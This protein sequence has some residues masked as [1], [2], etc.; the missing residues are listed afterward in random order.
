MIY[1]TSDTHLGHAKII[2][3]CH[4]PFSSLEEMD[5]TI[6]SRWNSRVKEE[7]TVFFLGDFCFRNSPG[8]REGI[9]T[10]AKT[11]ES[12]LNGKIVFIEG[13][14]D[15]NN[16]LKAKIRAASIKL[17]GKVIWAVHDPK[18]VNFDYT[19]NLVGHIH[20]K[21]AF[22]RY[23]RG[24]RISDCINVGVDVNNFMPKTPEELFTAHLRWSNTNPEPTLLD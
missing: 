11:W 1:L 24:N 9:P 13:N 10:H 14:H 17:C 15:H 5:N 7:D 22:M 4:R 16:T 12:L 2:D 20:E 19:I 23:K 18:R 3:Y 8:G 21:W 6:I